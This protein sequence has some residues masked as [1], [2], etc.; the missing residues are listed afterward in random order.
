LDVSHPYIV[1]KGS[2]YFKMNSFKLLRRLFQKEKPILLGRWDSIH[3]LRKSE[4]SNHDHCGTCPSSAL[5][6]GENEPRWT[7]E[8]CKHSSY[9]NATDIYCSVYVK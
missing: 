6:P 9:D 1:F 4:L 5:R 2:Q 3:S 8:L 7:P